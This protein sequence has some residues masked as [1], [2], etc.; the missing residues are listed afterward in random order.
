MTRSS[1]QIDA[2]SVTLA[3]LAGGQGSRMGGPK[4]EM[5]IDGRPILA[6]LLDCFFWPGPTLLVTAPGREHPP[7]WEKFDREVV[8]PVPDQG[9]IRGILTALENLQTPMLL[10]ATVDMPGIQAAQVLWLRDEMRMSADRLGLMLRRSAD[11]TTIEPFPS[12]FR[13][14]AREIISQRIQAG[15][16]SV[17]KLI[18]EK[19]FET[20]AAPASWDSRTWANLNVPADLKNFTDLMG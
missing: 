8:D 3:I 16:L 4:G 11:A 2:S 18:E 15:E 14:D 7:A 10:V 13:A 1:N 5:R 9:P 19:G 20:V 12:I 6:Y 17:Q